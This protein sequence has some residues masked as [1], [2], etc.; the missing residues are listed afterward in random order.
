MRLTRVH[1]LCPF[2]FLCSVHSGDS[3][4]R[5][6]TPLSTLSDGSFERQ[7]DLP[8]HTLLDAA[9]PLNESAMSTYKSLP[10]EPAERMRFIVTY[11]GVSGGSAEVI[12]HPPVKHAD[13]WAHRM[14][15]EVKSASWYRWI[16][17][18]HDSIEVLMNNGSEFTPARFY[19]NQMEG[20][21]RQSKIVEFEPLKGII[22]QITKRKGRDE[23]RASFPFVAGTKDALGALYYLRTQLSASNPPPA[24]LDISIFTSEKTWT[25]KATYLGSDTKKIGRK[26]YD[27]DVYRLITTFGGLMEQKGDIKMWFGRDERR[28]PLYIE[29]TVRFGYIKVTLDEWD[30][31][32]LRKGRFEAIRHRL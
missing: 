27:S 7:L 3:K 28:L 1:F 20:T 19:I 15:G 18:I 11:L 10:F 30:P 17:N 4:A 24:S 2:I 25:G 23:K 26:T 14:T 31:G 21:F 32:E 6:V 29:A 16:M 22:N 8:G 5:Q 12:L 13:A 9:S